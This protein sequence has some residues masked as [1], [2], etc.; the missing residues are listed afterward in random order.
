MLKREDSMT[1]LVML[2]LNRAVAEPADSAALTS[3]VQTW[4]IFSVTFSEICLEAAEDA[5]PT[6]DR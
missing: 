4:V 3:T 2:P 6:T 5:V 1:S